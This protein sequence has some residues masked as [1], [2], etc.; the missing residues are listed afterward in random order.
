MKNTYLIYKQ[1]DGTRQLAVASPSEWDAIMK[2]NK[3]LPLEKR[4]LFIKDSFADGDEMDCMYIEVN[5]DEFREWNNRDR[6]SRR[7]RKICSQYSN[8]S[9]D[10]GI[11]DTDVDSLHD[12]VPTEFNLEEVATDHILIEELRGALRNW[13]PW[14]MVLPSSHS[15]KQWGRLCQNDSWGENPVR[16]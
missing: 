14:A 11:A 7:K 13:K 3:G 16:W 5:A 4:R 6:V 9:L 8:L 12:T 2:E 15:L 1:I 10:A